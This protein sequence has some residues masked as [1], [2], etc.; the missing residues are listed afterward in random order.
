MRITDI[1]IDVVRRQVPSTGLTSDLGRFGGEVEQGVLRVHTDEG[2]EGNAFIGEHRQGGWPHFRP[3]LEG[4]KPE[5]VGRS[6]FERE[7]LWS[8][9]GIL[10]ARRGVSFAAW[11]PVDVAL[12]DIA[13][14]AAGMPIYELLGAQRYQT[15]VYATYPPR[16]ESPEG[17]LEEA[18]EVK[19]RGFRAYKIHPG[20]MGT[21]DTARMA[22]MARKT[23]GEDMALMLD[24][25]NNYDFRKALEVGKALDANGFY[26]YEDPVPW[27]DFDNIVDLTRRLDTPLAMSDL[28]EYRFREPAH[29]IRLGAPRILR[30]TARKQGITGLK[31]LCGMAE[32]FGLNCEIGLAGNS[33]LN[34]ANL[35]VIFSVSNC[36][37]YEYWM[38]QEAHQFGVVEDIKLNDRGVIEAPTAPGLG[39]ELDEDWIRGHTTQTLE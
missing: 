17:F 26:W 27:N 37:F 16:Y 19:A 20:V 31:K 23:V 32:A 9:L 6:A 28:A 5:L 11:S 33:L 13:G 18:E 14:K 3:I 29:Y 24:P 39:Y 38:P 22:D 7:W 12:W 30:G 4:L 8:R 25:N 1:T 2:I 21:R 10:A 36:D 34:A 35:H 15:D